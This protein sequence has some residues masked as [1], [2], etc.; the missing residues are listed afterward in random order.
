MKR[1]KKCSIFLR[2]DNKSGVCYICQ[3]GISFA[4]RKTTDAEQLKA[5]DFLIS[6]NFPSTVH[7]DDIVDL[8]CPHNIYKNSKSLDKEEVRLIRRT[9]SYVLK[10]HGYTKSNSRGTIWSNARLADTTC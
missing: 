4:R 5:K 2:S 8:I 6:N 1:C 9:V 7:R 3:T 10:E